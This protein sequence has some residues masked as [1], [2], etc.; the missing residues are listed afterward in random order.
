M[1]HKYKP[2][3]ASRGHYKGGDGKTISTRNLFSEDNWPGKYLNSK[4]ALTRPMRA[5]ARQKKNPGL[6]NR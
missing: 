6:E 2:S 4:H 1:A 5:Q 3:Q